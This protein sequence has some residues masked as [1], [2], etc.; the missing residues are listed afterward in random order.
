MHIVLWD[1]RK[2]G[3]SK[4]FAGGMGVGQFPVG[5]GLRGRLI[6]RFYTRDRR[7]VTLLYAHLAAIF[8]KLG[9]TVQYSEDGMIRGADVYVFNPSL[10][11]FYLERQVIARVVA[12]NPGARVL[13]LGT[14]ASVLPDAL[15]CR[16]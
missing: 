2:L 16:A 14:V 9:H 13:V 12:E 8:Q 1:T 10:I 6:R 11:T 7:P 15:R 3:V 4:D 5:G